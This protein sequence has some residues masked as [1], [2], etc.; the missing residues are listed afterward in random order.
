MIDDTDLLRHVPPE[1]VSRITAAWRWQAHR[2]QVPPGRDWR[3]WLLMA[4]RGFG[5]T[6]AGAEWVHA[7]ARLRPDA[8]IALVGQ[9]YDDARRVMVEGASGLIGIAGAHER[10]RWNRSKGELLFAS[11][12]VGFV[13]SAAAP[14]ALRGPEH[15]FAWC[16]E[17]AKWGRG[18]D[19]AWDNLTLGMRLG[20]MPRTIVTTTPRSMPLLH[21]VRAL[22]GT[23]E[24]GGCTYDN[25][26]L[27]PAFLAAVESAY[28]N[29]RLGRQEIEGKLVLDIEDSLFVRPVL[30]ASRIDPVTPAEATGEG[31]QR[32]VI[33]VDPVV[34]GHG[35][36]CGIVV[37][38]QRADGLLCVLAD[39]TV[40]R[41]TP[42]RWGRAVVAACL[43]WRADRVVVETNQGGDLV[44]QM[45]HAIDPNLPIQGVH[46]SRGKAHRAE[47]VSALF[48]RGEGALAGS[49]PALEDE[50]NGLRSGAPYA[51]PGR[52]PDRADA[53]V[54]AMAALMEG[55]SEPG[56][57]AIFG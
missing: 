18:G 27:P 55:R 52:S 23:I 42:L 53:M 10:P 40:E 3:V 44:K 17:L 31:W 9:N 24:D 13:Y 1:L 14:E 5:K 51:G 50:L 57:R 54:H 47:P 48:E 11:G 36:A 7:Q 4:G 34:T 21:R 16:D 46:A 28:A 33:G 20:A 37:C 38:G 12:A 49:F 6:R 56:M 25:P 45:L 30:E 43:R 19:S 26:H 41:A 32:I 35:D 29:T 2:G 22:A 39:V 8:R 15:H